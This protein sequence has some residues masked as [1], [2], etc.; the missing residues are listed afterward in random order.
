MA[1]AISL[2]TPEELNL[3]SSDFGTRY[4]I[5]ETLGQGGM[6]TV[7]KGRHTGLKKLVAIKVLNQ[8]MDMDEHSR[9]RFALEA[10]AGSKLSHPN[11]VS[12]FDFGFVNESIPYL[13]MEYIEG[14]SLDFALANYGRPDASELIDV[15]KQ[16]AKALQHIH[17][18]GIVHRD[19]KPSNI[20]IQLIDGERYVK[21]LD[22]GIAKF[23]GDEAANQHL[24]KTGAIFGSP[25]YM[26]PEQCIGKKTDARSDIYALGCVMYEC[27]DGQPP[28][29]GDNSLHT[30]F[31]HA[32][33]QPEPLAPKCSGLVELGFAALIHKCLETNPNSRFQT[34]GEVLAALNGVLEGVTVLSNTGN[35]RVAPVAR[36]SERPLERQ[37]SAE[38]SAQATPRPQGLQ[39]QHQTPSGESEA[40]PKPMSWQADSS[41]T[42]GF[43]ML[44]KRGAGD[45]HH[46]TGS[47]SL[48][49][50]KLRR[51]DLEQTPS[52]GATTL[53]LAA[54]VMV[55]IGA[56]GYLGWGQIHHN[57]KVDATKAAIT[58]ADKTFASGRAHYVE[59]QQQYE[60][61]LEMVES[62]DDAKGRIQARLG[63]ILA[64]KGELTV[65]FD[66]FAEAARRLRL[67]SQNNQEHYLDALVGMADIRSK[68]KSYSQ[69]EDYYAEARDLATDWR[70]NNQLADILAKS[71]KNERYLDYEQ[72]ANLYDQAI[73]VYANE[74]E[75]RD[76]A[77]ANTLFESAQVRMRQGFGKDARSR[78]DKALTACQE[79]PE[80]KIKESLKKRIVDL[81]DK[82][83]HIADEPPPKQV[84]S[85]TPQH[86]DDSPAGN[87]AAPTSTTSNTTPKTE[88]SQPDQSVQAGIVV[89][90]R[91]SKGKSAADPHARQLELM[92]A[93]T[94]LIQ[95]RIKAAR[96]VQNMM[97]GGGGWAPVVQEMD[98]LRKYGGSN[99]SSSSRP[100]PTTRTYSYSS[101]SGQQ[102][103]GV[104]YLQQSTDNSR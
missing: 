63:R 17:N 57:M 76:E 53:T 69:A 84:V 14:M 19:L 95:E 97:K 83:K 15:F 46:D 6:G 23:L 49:V 43:S 104:D 11:L 60:Q 42:G 45:A 29:L 77:L 1:E 92:K 75:T 33:E 27:M 103:E 58:T 86:F 99:S 68:Q 48:E 61:A 56:A 18:N 52:S 13:V 21:L 90:D 81:M 55:L 98:K 38:R 4:E 47:H 34:A 79:I 72:S 100:H 39:W 94:A 88:K 2:P 65:A 78:L 51:Q 26:S 10:Q 28:L 89:S 37:A 62:D 96:E 73:D 44:T 64:A 74:T 41:A 101:S 35:L 91:P 31:R 102:S 87:N 12:V 5:L 25:P 80:E 20:M 66:K 40:A 36:P 22:F 50:K 16:V 3:S 9:Q 54:C 67:N 93:E 70:R 24:T 71:A 85:K 59:A 8:D 30:V 82:A 32:N 7:I